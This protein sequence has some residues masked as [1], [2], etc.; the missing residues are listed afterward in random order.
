LAIYSDLDPQS[1]NSSATDAVYLSTGT[2]INWPA[3]EVLDFTPRLTDLD[4]G[5]APPWPYAYRAKVTGW[6]IVSYAVN[7]TTIDPHAPDAKGRAGCRRLSA[8]HGSL[9]G[10]AYAYIDGDSIGAIRSGTLPTEAQMRDQGHVYWSAPPPPDAM[11]DDVHVYVSDPLDHVQLT[12]AV[13]VEITVIN[14]YPGDPIDDPTLPPVEVTPPPAPQRQTLTQTFDVT[15]VVPR[16]VVG[17]HGT[18]D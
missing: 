7:G 9:A 14:A 8:P 6:V 4:L 5:Q 11:R 18:S 3:G 1:H 16:S 15:L 13:E 17:P 12:V 10:C 2:R